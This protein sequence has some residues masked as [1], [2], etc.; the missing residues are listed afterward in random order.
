[1]AAMH[2]PKPNLIRRLYAWSLTWAERP[3][4]A[5]ALGIF[6]FFE[7]SILPVPTDPLLLALCYAKPKRWWLLTSVC[8]ATSVAGG[9]FGWWIGAQLWHITSD[10][11]FSAIPGFTPERFE[12]VR[13]LYN[14]NA[15]LAVLTAAFTPIPYKIFTIASGVFEVAPM[16]VFAASALGRGARFFM[17][18]AAVRLFGPAVKP[19][20]EKYLEV[21]TVLLCL[22]G[23]LSFVALTWLR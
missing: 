6:S 15:F 2:L 23:I 18:A 20:L 14:R 12:A 17:Q 3:G 21:I 4:G 8:S 16:T 9:L 19:F 22:G 1:M 7:S 11:F 5:W 13:V 10:F